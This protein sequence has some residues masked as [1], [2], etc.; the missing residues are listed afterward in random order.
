M[1][2]NTEKEY[3][4]ENI[5]DFIKVPEG[6]IDDCLKEFKDFIEMYRSLKELSNVIG[7][8]IDHPEPLRTGGFV[9]V[10]DGKRER[11][12]SIRGI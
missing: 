5:E 4:I 9:W 7:D 12:I 2:M 10:D 1:G 8:I 6:R 11:T 3:R